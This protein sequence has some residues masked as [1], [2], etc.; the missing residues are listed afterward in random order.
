MEH[1]HGWAPVR[2]RHFRC[3][4]GAWASLQGGVRKQL[5]D[6]VSRTYED[7]PNNPALNS[8]VLNEPLSGA[9]N[10]GVVNEAP[11]SVPLADGRRIQQYAVEQTARLTGSSSSDPDGE[12]IE[13]RWS[14]LSGPTALPLQADQ[15]DFDVEL[16]DSIDGLE[17]GCNGSCARYE[18][19]L[20]VID[21]STRESTEI[22]VIE[23][24]DPNDPPEITITPSVD[25][26]DTA[27]NPIVRDFY[28]CVND[29]NGD[30]SGTLSFSV[31]DGS[32]NRVGEVA[33]DGS[34]PACAGVIQQVE[35]EVPGEPRDG[36]GSY[37]LT[38]AATDDHGADLP[39]RSGNAGRS[40]ATSG[41]HQARMVLLL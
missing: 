9:I 23:V 21:D 5:S 39:R 1:E 3:E 33:Y 29:P 12:I 7:N 13:Y 14:Q 19:A 17:N 27:D 36:S 37:R 8:N 4:C 40:D 6:R 35:I 2:T 34:G 26:V 15:P 30:Y 32:P 38:V 28:V 20:T 10:S 24:F 25:S 31:S 22:A 18:I 16:P 11:L 41:T